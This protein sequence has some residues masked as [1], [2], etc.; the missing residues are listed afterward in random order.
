MA[1][2]DTNEG[3]LSSLSCCYFWDP[4]KH[5]REL[6][7]E[8][9][10]VVAIEFSNVDNKNGDQDLAKRYL[11]CPRAGNLLMICEPVPCKMV[12]LNMGV[13][14]ILTFSVASKHAASTDTII[15]H[16]HIVQP[17]AHTSLEHRRSA[18]SLPILHHESNRLF[19]FCYSWSCSCAP[20][21]CTL[22]VL[23]LGPHQQNNKR[24]AGTFREATASTYTGTPTDPWCNAI[25]ALVGMVRRSRGIDISGNHQ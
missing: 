11:F 17:D 24:W 22:R 14:W 16:R 4:S 21:R 7:D 15:H 10:R 6:C 20:S 8:S 13:F 12:D 2:Q 19:P 1:S 23:L 3:A 5:I 9:V 18:Q 25:D